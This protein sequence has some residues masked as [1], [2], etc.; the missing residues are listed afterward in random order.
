MI[1]ENNDWLLFGGF[2]VIIVGLLR[3]KLLFIGFLICKDFMYVVKLVGVGVFGCDVVKVVRCFFLVF[4]F[5]FS[6]MVWWCFCWWMWIFFEKGENVLG[7][8]ILFKF[9]LYNW[10]LVVNGR[11]LR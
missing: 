1:L 8:S 4:L 2:V 5:F 11:W 6:L 7:G 9:I 10:K 3:L